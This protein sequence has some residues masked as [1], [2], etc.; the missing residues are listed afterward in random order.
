METVVLDR[1]PIAMHA[2]SLM[3]RLGIKEE[4]RHAAE[5]T[6]LLDESRGVAAPKVLYG[7]A[8]I[9][10]KGGDAIVLEGTRFTSRVLRVNVEQAHRV[11]PFVATCGRELEAWAHG[12]ND[13]LE[14]YWAESVK[15]LAVQLAVK[16]LRGH[17][18]EKYRSASL[19]SMAPG[20]LA[21]WPI[22]EQGVLFSL[23]GD[24][25]GAIGVRLNDS[26]MMIPEHSVSGILFPT[27]VRF[28][29][30]QLCSRENCPGRRASYDKDLYERKYRL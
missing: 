24:T 9:E 27:E 2:Q 10:E 11:F 13:I 3:K 30:C 22:E 16:F 4:N 21:D 1:I 8:Y 5:L 25:Q 14:R 18:T 23:L 29:S 26:F 19:S 6:T 7:A 20:S 28:E 17:L 15:Q 12:K